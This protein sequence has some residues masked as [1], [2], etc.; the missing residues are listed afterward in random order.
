MV[1]T[2]KSAPYLGNV[3]SSMNVRFGDAAR[4]RP[5]G[6]DWQ[7]RAESRCLRAPS[8]SSRKG[9]PHCPKGQISTQKAKYLWN[10]QRG[11]M[12]GARG[13]EPPTPCS[14]SRCATRLRYAPTV[15]GQV[16]GGGG[17]CKRLAADGGEKSPCRVRGSRMWGAR[18]DPR[19]PDPARRRQ[20]QT[21]A[22]PATRRAPLGG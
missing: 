17:D 12:V 6:A 18:R 13:F 10:R 2:A 9:Q 3:G 1:R 21:F 11:K 20:A 19:P 7:L 15:T 5:T 8:Q 4:Q 14:R 16:A 22:R